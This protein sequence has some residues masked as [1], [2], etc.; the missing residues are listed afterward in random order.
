MG[1]RKILII[2]ICIF[3]LGLS[4]T[5]SYSAFIKYLKLR[6]RINTT[7]LTTKFLS[8]DDINTKIE[9]IYPSFNGNIEKD[10]FVRENNFDL[11]NELD[12]PL[13]NI[14]STED[15]NVP[16]FLWIDNGTIYYYTIATNIDF[17]N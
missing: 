7:T 15:S 13:D 6:N 1:K 10:D 16:I 5:I 17:N 3:L 2:F 9:E 4:S 11:V 12:L 8:D 14:V